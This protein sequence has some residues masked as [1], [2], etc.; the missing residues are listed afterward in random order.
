MTGRSKRGSTGEVRRPNTGDRK[1]T[2]I[3]WRC[4]SAD[5]RALKLWQGEAEAAYRRTLKDEPMPGIWPKYTARTELGMAIFEALERNDKGVPK[6]YFSATSELEAQ[7]VD[8]YW[9]A[10]QLL[11]DGRVGAL[12]SAHRKKK[13]T[14]KK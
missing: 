11:D 7:Q 1:T 12:E 10:E 6:G 3:F 8:C 4:L 14:S 5:P 9:V 13:S 2:E